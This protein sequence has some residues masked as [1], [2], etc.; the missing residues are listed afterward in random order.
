[1]NAVYLHLKYLEGARFERNLHIAT[2]VK[3]ICSIADLNPKA[4]VLAVG[5]PDGVLILCL[6]G[7]LFLFGIFPLKYIATEKLL[8][9]QAGSEICQ[10]TDVAETH[11]FQNL[12][13]EGHDSG[14]QYQTFR[15][16]YD[17][18]DNY[19]LGKELDESL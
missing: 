13:T 11:Y 9:F 8:F 17:A 16:I 19:A 12:L 10:K 2:A 15:N 3:L 7:L 5:G 4:D 6:F 18:T 14:V 1:M